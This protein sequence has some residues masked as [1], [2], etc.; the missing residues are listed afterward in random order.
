MTDIVR[1]LWQIAQAHPGTCRIVLDVVATV[2]R[3]KAIIV[4]NNL[5]SAA[6]AERLSAENAKLRDL[7]QAMH[8][9]YNPDQS[10]FSITDALETMGC[11]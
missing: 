11:R 3:L 2:E 4:H 6:E 9:H 7:I 8:Q 1:E 10:P 5:V